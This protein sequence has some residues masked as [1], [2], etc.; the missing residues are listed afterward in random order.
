MY[1]RLVFLPFAYFPLT[2]NRKTGFIFPS[3]GQNNDR[4]YF[5]QNGGYYFAF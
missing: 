3:I 4:G 2:Q 5:F 1:L